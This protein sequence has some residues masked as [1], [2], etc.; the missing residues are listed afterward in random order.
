MTQRILVM[1]LPGSGKTFLSQYISEYLER[2]KKTVSWLN[3]D[4]VRKK[5]NDWDFSHDGRIRQ[6]TRMRR[7]ADQSVYQYTIIDMVSPLPEMRNIIEPDYIVFVDTIKEGRYTDTNK[8][9]V[10]PSQY[11]F[12]VTEQDALAWACVIAKKILNGYACS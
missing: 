4:D 2:E 7:L 11:D 1:G 9:F 10:P 12:H 6:A 8:L 3:A 5:Y